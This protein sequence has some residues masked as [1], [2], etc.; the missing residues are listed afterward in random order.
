MMANAAVPPGPTEEMA[1]RLM[2]TITSACDAS[3]TKPSGRRRRYAVY[4]WTSEIADLRCSCLRARTLA[5]RAR[6]QTNEG[7][8]QV[9]YASVRHLLRAA[10]KTSKRLCWIK[11]C[12]KV[13]EDAWGKPYETVMSRLRGPRENTPSSPTLVLR[14]VAAVFPR[15]PDEPALPPPLQA[16]AIVSSVNPEELRRACGRIKDHIAPGLDGVPNSAIKIAIAMHPDIFLKVY[17]AYLQTGVFPAPL[18]MLDTAGKI[19]ERIICDRLE[20]TIESPG[21]L[22]DHQYGFRK[23]RSTINAIEN[24]IT[25][26]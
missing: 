17:T 26:A 10:I 1:T 5:Q 14:I 20:A 15:G 21:S 24:V 18:C 9:K 7:A 23:G 22:S 25:T 11:L 13:K 3:M 16:G 12:D 6:D 19:L 8:S 4:W 2:A